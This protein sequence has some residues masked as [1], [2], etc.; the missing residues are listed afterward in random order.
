MTPS[1]IVV[2]MRARF[3]RSSPVYPTRTGRAIVWGIMLVLGVALS[4]R[5]GEAAIPSAF[6]AQ[7]AS[8]EG[9]VTIW[10]GVYTTDQASRGE[11][12]YNQSCAACHQQDLLGDAVT[13]ALVG[14]SFF[15][16][17]ADSTVDD[18]LRTMRR[19]MPMEAPD[20]LG[21][22][23]YVEIISYVLAANGG[24]TGAA[25]LPEEQARLQQIFITAR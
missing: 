23:A 14:E 11:Q 5:G 20:S 1:A 7:G 4:L 12:V 16:R 9:K 24:P 10:N 22:R 17:W 8:S 21:T 18:M 13:P 2:R 3:H 6:G 15:E 25:E 19:S